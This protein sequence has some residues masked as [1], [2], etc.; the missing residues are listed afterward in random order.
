MAVATSNRDS[1]ILNVHVFPSEVRN[2]SEPGSYHYCKNGD[3]PKPCIVDRLKEKFQLVERQMG[4]E[5]A[6]DSDLLHPIAGI[7]RNEVPL[8]KTIEERLRCPQLDID[9]GQFH[10]HGPLGLVLLDCECLHICGGK[11]T[12]FVE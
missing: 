11:V 3:F 12:N 5:L 6:R 10:F 8:F 7:P 2:L 4:W 1:T 9:G